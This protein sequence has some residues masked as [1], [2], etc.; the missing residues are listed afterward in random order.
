MYIFYF[1][2]ASARILTDVKHKN[3]LL[4]FCGDCVSIFTQAAR[5]F[6]IFILTHRNHRSWFVPY[7]GNEFLDNQ[8]T[9]AATLDHFIENTRYL[10]YIQ[11][12]QNKKAHTIAGPLKK[13]KEKNK[14]QTLSLSFRPHGKDL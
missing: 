1:K 5:I 4:V 9:R 6:P 10:P 3:K 12:L 13:I 14:K 2:V 7:A 11:R 8:A